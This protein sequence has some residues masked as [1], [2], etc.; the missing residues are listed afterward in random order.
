M[1][2]KH[3]FEV[4]LCSW[5][6]PHDEGRRL[7]AAAVPRL[8]CCPPSNY[9]S[10]ARRVSPRVNWLVD[11][12]IVD[13]VSLNCIQSRL[14]FS[15]NCTGGEDLDDQDEDLEDEDLVAQLAVRSRVAPDSDPAPQPFSEW[16]LLHYYSHDY[17]GEYI[18]ALICKFYILRTI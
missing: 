8:L 15:S 1:N 16:S 13:D 12:S 18:Y 17:N 4:F 9:F 10:I 7:L 5:R 14:A 3:A 6:R 2:Y 11:V